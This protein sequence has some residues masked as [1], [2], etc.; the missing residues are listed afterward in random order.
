M[1]VCYARLLMVT[2]YNSFVTTLYFD[3]WALSKF[4]ETGTEHRYCHF[5]NLCVF[6]LTQE[7]LNEAAS[8]Y[9]IQ[10]QAHGLLQICSDENAVDEVEA[11][12]IIL[13]AGMG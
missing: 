5:G 3:T 1:T 8:Q 10:Q 2:G 12:R 11:E 9:S 7:L 4:R 13:L 6:V